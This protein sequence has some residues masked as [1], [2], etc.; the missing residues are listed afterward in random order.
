MDLKNGVFNS[1]EI[2]IYSKLI[3]LS[4]NKHKKFRQANLIALWCECFFPIC[5]YIHQIAIM[6][7]VIFIIIYIILTVVGL[8]AIVLNMLLLIVLSKLKTNRKS[9]FVLVKSLAVADCFLPLVTPTMA[10]IPGDTFYDYILFVILFHL[11][12]LLME[13]FV[14]IVK[15][16][17]YINWSR[18][19][20][21]VCRLITIWIVPGVVVLL[22]LFIPEGLIELPGY[23]VS[24]SK[25]QKH[26]IRVPLIILCFVFMI[27]AYRYIYCQV[28]K[29]QRLDQVQNQQA[30]SNHRVLVVTIFN[31]GSFFLCWFPMV[32]I[33]I[34]YQYHTR[35]DNRLVLLK[36]V[37]P[38]IVLINC[39]CDPVIY[40]I[41]LREVNKMWRKTFCCFVHKQSLWKEIRMTDMHEVVKE[42]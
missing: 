14:A 19:R 28:R 7:P 34:L 35:Y 36:G 9:Y 6:M 25:S 17:H 2:F 24:I 38:L 39:V 31:M 21:I 16:L 11:I 27:L 32:V 8:T 3:I 33:E 26:I 20:Y 5:C 18:R 4:L 41:R 29:Q 15:P 12:A 1:T 40:A 42:Q 23:D 10:W 30:K 37:G 22:L 13:M